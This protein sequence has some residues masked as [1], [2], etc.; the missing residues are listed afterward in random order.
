MP[1]APRTNPRYVYQSP[2]QTQHVDNGAQEPQYVALRRKNRK[3]NPN[4]GQNTRSRIYDSSSSDS[5]YEQLPANR[6][7][8]VKRGSRTGLDR[9]SNPKSLEEVI[10]E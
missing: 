5:E 4:L 3:S 7:R 9:S 1:S 8:N 6:Y 2:V 10:L